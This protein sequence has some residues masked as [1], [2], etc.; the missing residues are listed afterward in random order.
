ML[1][2]VHFKPNETLQERTRFKSEFGFE[3]RATYGCSV[4]NRMFEPFKSC[5]LLKKVITLN[6]KGFIN[7]RAPRLHETK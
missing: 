3:H 5:S 6:P 1:N 2:Q 4:A 7:E